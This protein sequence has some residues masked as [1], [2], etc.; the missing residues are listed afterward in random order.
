MKTKVKLLNYLLEQWL[1]TLYIKERDK[2]EKELWGKKG[3]TVTK[4]RDLLK[5][6]AKIAIN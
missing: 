5:T 2:I 1:W 6:P 4:Q 3:G